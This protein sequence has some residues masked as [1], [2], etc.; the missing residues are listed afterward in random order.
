MLEASGE[1]EALRVVDA[2]KTFI[3]GGKG[4]ILEEVLAVAE[5]SP[6]RFVE[7]INGIAHDMKLP[8]G[9]LQTY[10]EWPE[11]VRCSIQRAKGRRGTR[12]FEIHAKHTGYLPTSKGIQI[13]MQQN[14]LGREE[15]DV[16]GRAPSFSKTVRT[17]VRELP[18]EE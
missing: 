17:V 13:A 14:N 8:L 7:L 2:R 6:R 11:L 18:S 12:D 10:M 9:T 3:G 15:P 5:M 1:E 4:I 16:P